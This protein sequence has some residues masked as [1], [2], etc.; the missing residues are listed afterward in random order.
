MNILT[1]QDVRTRVREIQRTAK[2]PLDAQIQIGGLMAEAIAAPKIADD[3][4]M[5]DIAAF[6]E[7]FGQKYVGEPRQMTADEAKFRIGCLRE[8]VGELEDAIQANDLEK[9]FDAI[10][11]LV[12]FALGTAY[13]QGL[14]FQRGWQRVHAANM[15]KELSSKKNPSKRDFQMDVVKPAGW[16]P[17]VLLDLLTPPI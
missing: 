16:T 11:D 5:L 1:L 15:A 2:S 17:P 7:K 14:P 6:H 4:Y 9:Q 8:E 10:I 12:Y 3:Q 13:R